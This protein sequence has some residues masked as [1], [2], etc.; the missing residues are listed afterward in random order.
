MWINE[1]RLAFKGC[2]KHR[3]T[4]DIPIGQDGKRWS[5]ESW[6]GDQAQLEIAGV[7]FL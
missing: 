5:K 7:L 1:Y 6:A 4:E 3:V 2:Q